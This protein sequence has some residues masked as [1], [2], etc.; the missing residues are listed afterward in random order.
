MGARFDALLKLFPIS[1]DKFQKPDNVRKW[2]YVNFK[3]TKTMCRVRV[4]G[5]KTFYIST[6]Y[7][8]MSE[9]QSKKALG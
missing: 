7:K 8:Y 2:S 3:A 5:F 4:I 1:F 9:L 6:F